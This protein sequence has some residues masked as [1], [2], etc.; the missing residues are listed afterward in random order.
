[1]DT[2]I[3]TFSRMNKE[4]KFQGTIQNFNGLIQERKVWKIY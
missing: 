4:N 2:D 3:I 1:M